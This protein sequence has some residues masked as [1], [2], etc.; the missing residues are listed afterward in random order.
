MYVVPNHRWGDWLRPLSSRRRRNEKGGWGGKEGVVVRVC[1]SNESS[2]K[3]NVGRLPVDLRPN[4]VLR[5]HVKRPWIARRK[6][7][8]DGE[9]EV[10]DVQPLSTSA[11][12]ERNPGGRSIGFD[13]TLRRARL[14]NNMTNPCPVCTDACVSG[15]R[16]LRKSFTLGKG[17]RRPSVS[18]S[19]LCSVVRH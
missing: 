13:P 18:R 7:Y 17:T 3:P 15:L 5:S 14:G 4:K 6:S 11:Q 2:T 10:Q 16:C 19:W 12:T 1:I 9:S 8:E